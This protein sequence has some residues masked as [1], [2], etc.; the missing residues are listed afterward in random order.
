MY[1]KAIKKKKKEERRRK[2]GR[3]ILACLLFYVCFSSAKMPMASQPPK[4]MSLRSPSK[5]S[6]HCS[7]H[8]FSKLIEYLICRRVEEAE[9]LVAEMEQKTEGFSINVVSVYL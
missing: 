3:L 5:S 9:I 4:A 2:K 6:Y 7:L 8:R 1:V